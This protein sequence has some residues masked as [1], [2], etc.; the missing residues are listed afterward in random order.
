MPRAL[1][2]ALLVVALAAVTPPAWAQEDPDFTPVGYEF[3]GWRD[4]QSGGWTFE[5]PDPGVWERL[6]ARG[7]TCRSARSN[8]GRLRYTQT[9]PFRPVKAG[10]R[11]VTL[12]D[13]LEYHSIRCSKRGRPRVAFRFEGGA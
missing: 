4:F 3:C 9:P 6:F 12:D 11:C 8:Y 10:Y 1:V 13:D 2:A 5:E 7:M